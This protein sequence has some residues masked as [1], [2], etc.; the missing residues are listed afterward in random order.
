M[1][2]PDNRIHRHSVSVQRQFLARAGLSTSVGLLLLGLLAPARLQGF[3]LFSSATSGFSDILGSPNDHWWWDLNTITYAFDPSF[4]ALFPN[5]A[6]KDQVRLGFQQWDNANATVN[7]ANYSY[8]RANGFQ[9]FGDIRSIFVHELGHVLGLHHAD[10]A[11]AAGRNFRPSGATFVA[12]VDAG[13]EVMRSWINAGDYNHILSHDELDAFN[14]FVYPARNLN[15]VEVAPGAS[16]NILIRSYNPSDPNNWANGGPSGFF[17][18]AADHTQGAR[19]TTGTIRFNLAPGDP[20]GFRTLGINWDY[21]N[22]SGQPTRSFRV[23]TRGTDNLVPIFHY[24]NNDWPQP[25]LGY[26]TASVGANNKDDVLH[27]W[28]NP[29]GGDIP[30]SE[31]LHVGLELDV[32]DW[33]VVSASTVSPLG[34][35]TAAPVTWSHSWNNTIVIG[36]PA[37]AALRATDISRRGQI[38]VLARGFRM[39]VTDV[40]TRVSTVAIADVTDMKLRLADLNRKTLLRLQDAQRLQVIDGF[41]AQDFEPNSDFIFVLEGGAEDLPDKVREQ[42]NFLL[43]NRPDLVDRELFIY[44]ASENEDAGIGTYALIGTPVIGQA[45]L[46]TLEIF[47]LPGGLIRICWPDP[48]D[49]YVLQRSPSLVPAQWTPGP[50]Q[51]EIIRRQEMRDA[52][53][54]EQTRI[55]PIAQ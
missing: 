40:K 29:T 9:P 21:Q 31:I 15:F 25:F 37:V 22:V 48:S 47:K 52:F 4:D 49:G 53:R 43:L 20:L 27:T 54:A 55:L 41:K 1:Q 19:A 32:W 11:A 7:G 36:T 23:R 28:S 14:L 46:P 13:N 35:I 3:G 50:D 42:G 8:N 33:T 16:P 38:R 44:T 34:T 30:A 2:P 26:A 39:G 12:Q 6:I 51:V 5:P 45:V 17:R 10:Q 18:N 24:D